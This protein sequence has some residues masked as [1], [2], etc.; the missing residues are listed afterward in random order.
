MTM[1]T[2]SFPLEK[3]GRISALIN[4][5]QTTAMVSSPPLGGLLVTKFTW[6]A[7]FGINIPLQ[8][9]AFGLSLYG[10]AGSTSAHHQLSLKDKI[11]RLDL[12]G[13]LMVVPAI[14][15]LLLGLQWGGVQYSWSSVRIIVLLISAVLLFAIF[16]YW[17]YRLGGDAV[18]PPKIVKNR[19]VWAGMVFMACC[20]GTLAV[21]EY[22]MS[23]YFQG[24][25]GY[26]AWKSGLLGV[27]MIVGLALACL[28]FGWGIDKI[29][30][31]NRKS[32]STP[33]LAVLT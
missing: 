8:V 26:S 9:L 18:L 28:V 17:Q 10:M 20:D 21:T 4:F 31:Y 27:P 12:L 7:C 30:Y 2:Q 5:V 3:R 11:K 32:Y 22:F 6:R 14:T 15:C 13:T 19:N 16:G 29:G 24:V 1:L 23:I 25:R 33:M